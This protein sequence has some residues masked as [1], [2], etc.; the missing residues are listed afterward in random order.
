MKK[1]IV[2]LSLFLILCMNIL[3]FA[4]PKLDEIKLHNYNLYSTTV[5]NLEN[6][7]YDSNDEFRITWYANGKPLNYMETYAKDNKIEYQFMFTEAVG[8]EV[9]AKVEALNSGEVAYTEKIILQNPTGNVSLVESDDYIEA[10]VSD[11]SNTTDY[12]YIWIINGEKNIGSNKLKI[13]DYMYNK[14]IKCLVK[15]L[16]TGYEVYSNSINLSVK[17]VIYSNKSESVKGEW[18]KGNSGWWYSCKD[19]THPV[20]NKNEDGSISYDWCYIDDKWFAFDNYGYV[21]DG[22]IKDANDG[23]T[24]YIDKESGLYTG[25]HLIDNNWYYFNEKSDGELGKL[26]VNTNTPDGYY[27]NE[28]GVWIS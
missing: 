15:S 23:E 10:L 12:E 18:I 26:Y 25:W 3:C 5:L 22:F 19:G 21:V 4:E 1:R 7:I 11:F 28:F 27:V 8:K 16:N 9:Y 17:P 13:S 24:Y 6:I 14:E 20:G 2:L